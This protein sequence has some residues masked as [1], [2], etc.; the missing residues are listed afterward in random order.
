M[1]AVEA[2]S[3]TRPRL[4][5]RVRFE[6][7]V[8]LLVAY[9]ALAVLYAWQAWRREVPTI[10]TDELEMTQLS[11]SIAETGWPA[12]RGESYPF[13]TLVPWLTAP[14][15]WIGDTETAFATIKY[16]QT[17]VMAA[18]IFP[19]YLLARTVVSR[20]WAVFAAVAAIA[21]PALSYAPILVEEPFAY[22]SATLAFWL[23]VRMAIRPTWRSVAL[24]AGGCVLATS[25]R[26][27]LVALFGVMLVPLLVLGW[28]SEAMRRYR[29]TWSRWD[30]VGA[31][32]LGIGAVLFV[33][34]YI[35]HRSA[36]WAE[37]MSLWK[38]R[39]VEY[40]FWAAGAFAIGVGILPLIA[41]L[42]ALARPR[43]ELRDPA[44]RA[45]VL[46]SGAALFFLGFYAGLKGGYV[47]T[48]LGSY[49]VERN[50]IYLAPIAFVSTAL[51]L[52]RRNPRWWAVGGA[53][54]FVVYL[55]I[56]VPLRL[57]QYPYYEAHGLAVLAF[58]NRVLVWSEPTIQSCLIVVALVSCAALLAVGLLRGGRART[59]LV[60]VV[61]GVVLGWNLLTEVYAANGERRL[62]HRM[63]SSFNQQ[64]T[65]VDT[66]AGDGTVTLVGQQ[67]GTDT[68]GINLIEF[69]NRSIK[70]VW[71]VDPSSSAPGPG[72][73]QTPD[74]ISADG[75]LSP[76]PG[77]D[78]ALAINGVRLQGDVVRQLGTATLYRL[79]GP[80][81]L[82]EN[83]TG[84][85]TDGWTGKSAA[86]NRFDVTADG[87]VFA[88]VTL[89]REGFCTAAR[90]PSTMRVR[91]GP[92][93]IGADKQPSL[94]S[95]TSSKTLEVK[96]CESRTILLRPPPGPWRIEVDA[97]TFSPAKLDPRSSDL[98]ELGARAS[99]GIQPIF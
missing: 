91:I 24:A 21:A 51:L 82:A 94:A 68:N 40:G 9:F 3:P 80:F 70:H 56:D 32:T 17:L 49:V 50:L 65:W 4:V 87:P 28:R 23:L 92:I 61:V 5:D 8:P 18:T 39:I 11:R 71:S 60:V 43:E 86:Y 20:P 52:E 33:M 46:V 72:P 79:D 98:R 77:T 27:Q 74:L 45:Y 26:S 38:G 29:T 97:E 89:S 47:S 95:V 25:I 10:F 88:R 2:A 13:T 96:P 22:P 19:A 67:F 53:T 35:G 84:V 16:L 93:A 59:A 62:S 69:F 14:G 7:L 57:D 66:A 90:V 42:A 36:D 1:T 31:V 30:W 48:K 63:A 58:A 15:W 99:F 83:Q 37:M 44:T 41:A 12:R 78:Y 75:Q 55:V 81:R 34:A 85:A 54:A 73:T 76:E 64:R 6:T